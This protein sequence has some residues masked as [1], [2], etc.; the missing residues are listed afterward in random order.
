MYVF[1]TNRK[2]DAHEGSYQ[3]CKTK[4]RNVV[5]A[6]NPSPIASADS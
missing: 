3:P 1:N 4:S 5:E 2:Y 6:E